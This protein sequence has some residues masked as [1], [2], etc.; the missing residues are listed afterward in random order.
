MDLSTTRLRLPSINLSW[1]GGVNLGTDGSFY[2]GL[3]P[4]G[5]NGSGT[6]FA[7]SSTGV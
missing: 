3:D 4:R 2:G 6:A 7:P 5:I 1:Y